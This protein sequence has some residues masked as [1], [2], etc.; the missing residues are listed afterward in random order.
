MESR[1]SGGRGTLSQR[2][3]QMTDTE[4]SDAMDTLAAQPPAEAVESALAVLEGLVE[5]HGLIVAMTCLQLLIRHGTAAHLPRL[6]ALRALPAMVALRDWRQEARFTVRLLETRARGECDCVAL[7][8][9]GDRP[10]SD[11][12][13]I[14]SETLG[15]WSVEMTVRCRACGCGAVVTRDD[16]Y[17]YPVFRWR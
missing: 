7:R 4:K 17:H 1:G 5:A 11:D 16:G 9:A 14:L 12:F 2:L 8:A 15:D 3:L 6:R 10:V 13:E